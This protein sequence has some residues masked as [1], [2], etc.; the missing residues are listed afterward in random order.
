MVCEGYVFTRV[1]HSFCSRGGVPDQVPP[2]Q[3]QPPRT[4]YTPQDQVP[5]Q[6]RYPLDQVHPPGPGPPDQVH[7]LDRVH[8]PLTRYPPDQV[9]PEQSML[10]DTVNVRA[11]RIPLECNL[12]SSIF[13]LILNK[14]EQFDFNNANTVTIS[15]F[16]S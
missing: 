7:P 13:S 6:T 5:P 11:V 15:I 14:F 1:C 8:L 2:D 12:V 9:P 3:V 16:L 10:G 4:R